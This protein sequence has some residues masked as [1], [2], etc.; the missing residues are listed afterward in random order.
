VHGVADTTST[1]GGV[2]TKVCAVYD[3]MIT[4]VFSAAVRVRMHHELVDCRGMG[5]GG[6]QTG[7]N[8]KNGGDGGRD[9]SYKLMEMGGGGGV[10][11]QAKE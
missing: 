6:G 8:A 10:R 5:H 1:P 2:K 9:K 3:D 4:C 7:S 11:F